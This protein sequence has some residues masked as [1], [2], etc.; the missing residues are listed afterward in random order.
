MQSNVRTDWT[1][2][3]Q[4]GGFSS[5]TRKRSRA[6]HPAGAHLDSIGYG[7]KMTED[8]QIGKLPRSGFV[9]LDHTCKSNIFNGSACLLIAIARKN[10]HW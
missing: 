9:H 3:R 5:G 4:Y 1:D 10:Q 2:L 7:G 8:V 6:A